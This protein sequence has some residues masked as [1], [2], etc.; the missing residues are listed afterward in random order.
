[1]SAEQSHDQHP[2]AAVRP[3]AGPSVRDLLAACAAARTVSTPP[4]NPP[5]AAAPDE[6][7]DRRPNRDAA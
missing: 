4:E 5:A 2:D 7:A 3:V 1:M 6:P